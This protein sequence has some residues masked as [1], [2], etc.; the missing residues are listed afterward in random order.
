MHPVALAT[1]GRRDP[2]AH[3]GSRAQTH[4]LRVAHRLQQFRTLGSEP[5]AMKII[6]AKGVHSPRP[7]MEPIAKEMIWVATPGVT[8]ADL[9][10][11]T[12][13]QRRVPLYPLEPDARWP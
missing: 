8:T 10:T 6:V 11:F 4:N 3:T 5:T 9:S 12:Y 7:A 2:P 1:H 13:R